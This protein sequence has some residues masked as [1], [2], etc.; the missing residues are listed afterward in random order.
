MNWHRKYDAMPAETPI[1][2]KKDMIKIM[3]KEYKCIDPWPLTHDSLDGMRHLQYAL[4]DERHCDWHV[5]YAGE[6]DMNIEYHT[7]KPATLWHTEMN[8]LP[9]EP[10]EGKV[11]S[12]NKQDVTG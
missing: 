12:Q 5:H 3:L 7:L 6:I 11:H 9:E 1:E 8:V 2:T 10:E 4:E